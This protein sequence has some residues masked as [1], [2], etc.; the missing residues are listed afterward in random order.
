MIRQKKDFP[1]FFVFTEKHLNS[2]FIYARLW[3]KHENVLSMTQKHPVHKLVIWHELYSRYLL[4][5]IFFKVINFIIMIKDS[6]G[7]G[8]YRIF[9][10]FFAKIWYI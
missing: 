8:T 6:V 7:S 9:L 3:L 5:S 10:H 2:H 1:K 4:T